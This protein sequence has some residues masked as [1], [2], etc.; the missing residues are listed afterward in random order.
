[1]RFELATATRIVFG[2]GVL[3]E[4]GEIV[5]GLG[6]RALL[7]TGR[8]PER[9]EP[10][11]ERLGAAGVA[12]T[13]FSAMGEPTVGDVRR[14]A[15]LARSEGA[16]VVVACGG[17][18]A[19]DAGKVIAALLGNGGDPLAYLEVVGRGSPRRSPPCRSSRS[20]R[21]RAPARRS[22]ATPCSPRRSTG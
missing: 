14:G 21:R 22:R 20:R 15:D 8:T 19:I 6:S 7:V 9:A 1:M 18:S 16:D 2:P 11:R 17:G 13:T 12:S 10:A 4:L 3:A 5:A